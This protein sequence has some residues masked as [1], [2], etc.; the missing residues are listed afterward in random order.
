MHLPASTTLSG[1]KKLLKM[2]KAL[3]PENPIVLVDDEEQ[4][5]QTAKLALASEG[6]SNT[7]ICTDS[8]KVLQIVNEAG[9]GTVVL[10]LTMPYIT[11]QE[12]LPILTK[13][14]PN[15]TVIIITAINDV[16][17]AVDCM[18]KGA[19]D[20]ILK[21]IRKE[22]LIASIRKAFVLQEMKSEAA[23]LKNSVLNNRIQS[24]ECFSS[25]VTRNEVMLNLFKY[26]EAIAPTSLPVLIVG[27]TGVGKE[28]MARAV[29]KI[30]KR[31][32][33]FVCVNAA[34][35]DD[36]MF[37][38]TL[39]G[40][41]KGA[42]SGADT[43]RKG[44]LDEAT[45]GTIFLDEIGDLR[46]ESQVKLLR[47]LQ[48]GTYFPL[49]SDIAKH[50]TARII[51]ATNKS[52]KQMQTNGSFRRDL[53]Y[54][55]E[56]HIIAIPPLRNR[57]DDI[58]ILVDYLFEQAAIELGKKKPVYPKELLNLLNFYSFPGNLRELR[59][60]IFDALSQHSSGILSLDSFKRKIGD[61]STRVSAS[62][63]RPGKS[64]LVFPDSLPSL[65]E[66]EKALIEESL[67]RAGGN[68]SL[69]AHMIGLTRQTLNNWLKKYQYRE[70]ITEQLKSSSDQHEFASR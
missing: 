34:G 47:L 14:F 54:R 63:D 66:T 6:V 35:V 64:S 1:I 51:T 49:G 23:A 38:D 43:D 20:Y 69:A 5:L 9:A 18:K 26:T 50:S 41:R 29:H 36:T 57:M 27:E 60:M 4:F 22:E 7:I 42:F 16:K 58:P 13:D 10:D 15:I 8:R 67:K 68:K 39:F 37:S 30:S 19:F 55:L 40:H 21:P 52:L 2:E 59:G 12:L 11:G 25:I 32:G 45:G 56:A 70:E 46:P 65:E 31:T 53:Y 48:E 24:P 44:L 28:L 17:T 61:T 62:V 33:N 3:F